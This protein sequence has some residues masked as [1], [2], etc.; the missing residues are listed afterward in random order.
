MGMQLGAVYLGV[1]DANQVEL[2]TEAAVG[3][4]V[5]VVSLVLVL[6]LI[7][8][9]L[10]G[11]DSDELKLRIDGMKCSGCQEGVK[12]ALE[13]VKGVTSATV[14]LERGSAVVLGTASAESL[15]QAVEAMGK[16]ATLSESAQRG[17]SSAKPKTM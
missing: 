15:I 2:G 13:S 1:S 5:G 8:P 11:Q 12:K 14:D 10:L 4:L 9:A 16:V 6:R 17:T 3:M 7:I